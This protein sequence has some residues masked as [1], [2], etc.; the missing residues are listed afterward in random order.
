MTGTGAAGARNH[1][2]TLGRGTARRYDDRAAVPRP[3][4]APKLLLPAHPR[5]VRACGKAAD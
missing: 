4:V 1:A 2:R 5:Q 3:R